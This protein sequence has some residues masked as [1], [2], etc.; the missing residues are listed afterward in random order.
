MVRIVFTPQLRRFLDVPDVQARPGPLRAV[1]QQAFS[2]QPRL[3]GY[4]LDDQGHLRANVVVFIDGR[5]VA[6]R[7]EI[8]AGL[9]ANA[10]V[11]VRGAG[12]LN[13]G[14][15][16]RVANDTAESKPKQAPA[17]VPQ[18]QAASK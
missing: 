8:T 15:L 10:T 9:D 16:V 14:D 7:V 2:R 11:A 3:A 18:S 4:V 13:E 12:F 17:P 6:D 1:L 5:R